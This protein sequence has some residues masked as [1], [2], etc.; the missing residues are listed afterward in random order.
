MHNYYKKNN[1]IP[2]N[3]WNSASKSL[4]SC[5]LYH[6]AGNNPIKYLDP[7]G[8]NA[9][10]SIDDNNHTVTITVPIT[11]YGDGAS[12]D[13]AQIYENGINNA[14]SGDWTTTIEGE[15][16][17]VDI[18]ANV[19]VGVE[20]TN[21]SADASMNYVKVDETTTRSSVTRGYQGEWR[22]TGRLGNSLADDNPAPH[23]TGHFLGLDDRYQDT[24][25]N[26]TTT[27]Q[28]LDGWEDNIMG[29]GSTV[30]QRNIDGVMRAIPN[31]SSIKNGVLRSGGMT[32]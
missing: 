28:A 26:G 5:H 24:Q 6:Y 4:T 32:N 27:S 2:S 3:N 9:D 16:Y 29:G 11:I 17:S 12:E 20:P 10:Y 13:I 22:Q 7:D 18:S 8:K 31:P 14:W 21:P 15:T 23:E 19:R 1:V 25:I 30:E